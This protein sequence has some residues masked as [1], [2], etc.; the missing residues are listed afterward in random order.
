MDL[1]FS[2]M[3][4]KADYD[5]SSLLHGTKLMD[6]TQDF[7]ADAYSLLKIIFLYLGAKQ[8]VIILSTVL[9]EPSEEK[10][11]CIVFDIVLLEAWFLK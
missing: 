5:S 4:I 6:Q 9:G 11:T 2:N 7:I 3:K 8:I 10:L 1:L